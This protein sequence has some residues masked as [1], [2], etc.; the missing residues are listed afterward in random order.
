MGEIA[1]NCILDW[2]G[3]EKFGSVY[4]DVN[5][6]PGEPPVDLYFYKLPCKANF[7]SQRKLQQA[8]NMKR[9]EEDKDKKEPVDQEKPLPPMQQK[10]SNTRTH[11]NTVTTPVHN[12]NV[13]VWC[14]KE[15]DKN[16][17]T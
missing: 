9:T 17:F 15:E 7:S 14:L 3:F 16:T 5:M 6:K 4:E 1:K 2:Q 8:R 13:C 11:S 12:K 10:E